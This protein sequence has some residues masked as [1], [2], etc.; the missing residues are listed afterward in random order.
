[1]KLVVPVTAMMV[2]TGFCCCCGGGD[3]DQVSINLDGDAMDRLIHEVKSKVGSGDSAADQDDADQ[4]GGG[5]S[6][7]G[8][9][10]MA[11]GTCGIFKSTRF[12]AP[13]GFKVKLCTEAAQNDAIILEGA[14]TPADACAVAK[15][16]AKEEGYSIVAESDAAGTIGIYATKGDHSLS[17]G[18]NT[19]LGQTVLT[20]AAMH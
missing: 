20:V 4:G 1:M 18:C 10:G 15:T 11:A 2:G 7:A 8:V 9:T 17:V 5:A 16:W 14:G 6:A 3:G 13:S 19:V 12:V